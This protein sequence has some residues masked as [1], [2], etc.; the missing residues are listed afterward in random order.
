MLIWGEGMLG[1]YN[2]RVARLECDRAARYHERA[3]RFREIAK[4]ETRP[5]ARARLLELAGQYE[6]LVDDLAGPG[7]RRP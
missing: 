2:G 5:R 7:P 1:E 3:E 6:Q 4:M